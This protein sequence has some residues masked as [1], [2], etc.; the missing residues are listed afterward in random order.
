MSALRIG[1]GSVAGLALVGV[2]AVSLVDK[3]LDQLTLWGTQSLL[4]LSLV[5]VWGRGGMFS[6]GQ[7]GLFGVGA[8]VFGIVSINAQDGAYL[9]WALIAAILVSGAAAAVIGFF[10]FYGK[11]SELNVAIITLAMTLVT[12]AVLNNLGD[13]KYAIGDAVIGGYNG[14]TGIPMT[15]LGGVGSALLTKQQLFVLV[16]VLVVL[17][18]A[19]VAAV[20]ASPFGRVVTAIRSNDVRAELL[21][22]D[23]RRYR[24]LTFTFGGMIAGWAGGLFAAWSGYV[25]PTLF[26]L[27]PAILVIIWVLAG[28]RTAVL[29]GVVGTVLV[30]A[31]TQGFSGSQG[32]Y[33][34]IYLGAALIALVMLAPQGVLGLVASLGSRWRRAPAPVSPSRRTSRPWPAPATAATHPNAARTDGPA[35][36]VAGLRKTFGGFTA[37]DSVDLEVPSRGVHCIIGPNGA[38]K[39]TLFGLLVGLQPPTAGTIELAGRQARRLRTHRRV[40]SGLGIKLQTAS[41]FDEL[42]VRENLWLASYASLGARAASRRA[43]DLLH[44]FDLADRADLPATVLSHGEQQWLEIAMVSAGRPSVL[45]LDEPTGGMTVDETHRTAALVRRLATEASVV[46]IEHDMAFVRDLDAEITVLHLGRVMARGH[47]DDLEQSEEIRAVYLGGSV[48]HA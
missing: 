46:V 14:M 19:V 31:L 22:Y 13:P 8:Y 26:T 35:L 4:A 41:V 24:L 5:V 47:L 25:S 1:L 16:G 45:L 23:V 2:L 30:Q 15:R 7:S 44:E 43:D 20:L 11:V 17:T 28:G 39:S 10:I 3:D 12:Y 32:E 18:T 40:R 36:R 42:T 48:A 21:G 9:P 33:A 37:V 27:Q 38:G 34:P 29:G 6:L